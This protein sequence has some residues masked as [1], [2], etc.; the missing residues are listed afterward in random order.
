MPKQPKQANAP[1]P[2]GRTTGQSCKGRTTG[3]SYEGRT[4][5]P[6][7]PSSKVQKPQSDEREIEAEEIDLERAMRE[8]NRPSPGTLGGDFKP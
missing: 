6:A 2:N 5:G 1:T 8:A 4:T 3:Q 7:S